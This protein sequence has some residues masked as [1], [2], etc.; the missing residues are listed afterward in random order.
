MHR[1]LQ[2]STVAGIEGDAHTIAI[3]EEL[4]RDLGMTPVRLSGTA[5]RALYHAAAVTVAGGG[6]AGGAV[7]QQALKLVQPDAAAAQPTG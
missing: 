5:S 1:A 6:D 4:A 2:R 7:A 3:A